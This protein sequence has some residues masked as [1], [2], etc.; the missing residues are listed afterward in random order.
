MS[1]P[2]RHHGIERGGPVE[3]IRVLI[4]DDHVIVREG[5]RAILRALPGIEPVGEARNG[6]E[7]LELISQLPVDVVLMDLVMPEM[8][9]LEA[10]AALGRLRPDLPVIAL[11][12]FAEGAMVVKAIQA[13][14]RGFLIKDA[15]TLA[16][17]EA[18]RRVHSGQ[19][20]LSPEVSRHLMEATL[21]SSTPTPQLTRREYEVLGLL[22][23]GLTNRQ[24]AGTL[25]VSENTA[26][27]HVSNILGKLG[28]ASRTQAAIYAAQHGLVLPEA[29]QA[30]L[31]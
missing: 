7:A 13:G 4:V 18:I 16:L 1:W 9:G 12:S 22:A 6:H 24:I 28:L 29:G 26:G 2:L 21:R 31:I 8:G 10:L 25:M 14:A 5:L 3:A 19:P 15:D 20:Y 17:A 27:V 11:T 30:A 23:R